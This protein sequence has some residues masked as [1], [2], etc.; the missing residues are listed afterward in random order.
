MYNT[1]KVKKRKILI[2]ASCDFCPLFN[3]ET[4][5]CNEENKYIPPPDIKA[6]TRYM[7]DILI[8]DWCPL[9]SVTIINGGKSGVRRVV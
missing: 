1:I 9:E 5:V 4:N 7:G 3:I 6:K 2:I 8:P